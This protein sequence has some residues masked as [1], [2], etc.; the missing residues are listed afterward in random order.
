MSSDMER[1][2]NAGKIAQTLFYSFLENTWS[3]DM[4]NVCIKRDQDHRLVAVE[5]TDGTG[6]VTA[7]GGITDCWSHAGGWLIKFPSEAFSAFDGDAK[8]ALLAHRNSVWAFVVMHA[9]VRALFQDLV[10][11]VQTDIKEIVHYPTKKSS[12]IVRAQGSFGFETRRR[13]QL[14]PDVDGRGDT[15]GVY[16]ITLKCGAKIVLDLAGAQWEPLNGEGVHKPV[17][18]ST[19]YWSRWGVAVKYRVPFCSHQLKHAAKMTK[20][21]MITSQT[22]IMEI[23]LYFNVFMMSSCKA[24]LDFHPR[25]LLDME[26]GACRSAKQRFFAKTL[27]YLKRRPAEL[28]SGKALDVLNVLNT[29]DLRHPKVIAEQPAAQPRGNGSLPLDIGS[30]EKFDWKEFSR[31]IRMPSSEVTLKEKK[32]AKALQKNRSVYKEP[33]SWK[34]VFLEDTIPGPRIPMDCISENAAWRLE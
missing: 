27:V 9:A 34:M 33:G 3:Y 10:E 5:V 26:S 7:S 24:E 11:D 21:R 4:K 30:M 31:L 8:H 19:D 17:T 14:Y 2:I 29:F 18:Y 16:E 15:K 20:Y 32:R 25:E 28:D 6:V 22:L 13:D 23:S 1:A 12:R